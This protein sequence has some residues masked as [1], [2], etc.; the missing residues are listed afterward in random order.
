[1]LQGEVGRR[2]FPAI[3]KIQIHPYGE[4]LTSGPK[5]VVGNSARFLETR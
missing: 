4:A 3:A 2:V 5:A 1:M